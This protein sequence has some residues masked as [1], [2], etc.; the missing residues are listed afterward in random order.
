MADVKKIFEKVTSD[1]EVQIKQ[2]IEDRKLLRSL[3]LEEAEKQNEKTGA[4]K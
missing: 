2:L 4:Q 1:A 3:F